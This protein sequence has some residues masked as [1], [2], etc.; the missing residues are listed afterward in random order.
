MQKGVPRLKVMLG[1]ALTGVVFLLGST[2]THGQTDDHEFSLQVSPSP[3]I[4]TVK[5]GQSTRLE[6]KVRNAGPAIEYL[7]IAPRSFTIDPTTQQPHI[8][9]AKLPDTASWIS[10]A[11]PTFSVR[12]GETFTEKVTLAVPKE[13]G[14][15]YAFS[16][17]INRTEAPQGTGRLL[18]GS[19][20]IFTLI[21]VDRPGAVRELQLA[22]LKPTQGM[23]EYLPA[24]FQIQFKNT[25]N[26]IVQPTG[27][28]FV[29]RGSQDKMPL[30]TL[31]VND[32]HGYILPGMVRTVSVKWDDGF[33]ASVD[34]VQA[35][36]STTSH[37]EWDWGKLGKLRIGRY[38]A[39]LVAIYDDGHR[40]VPV[41]G[42]VSFWVIPW[43]ILLGVLLV[44]VIIGFG[45]WSMVSKVVRLARRGRR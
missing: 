36:G 3:L 21:N 43:K 18:K 25:G 15:S 14:F 12:P 2:V 22:N 11:Q 6:L 39:K 1:V 30:A 28:L 17:V 45:L 33:P 40:D 23:Y 42:E 8:D 44:V 19:V 5:P 24:E 37:L 34:D 20:A 13:A 38:T 16:L 41:L 7:K 31:P 35:D 32:T 4:S 29:Q 27:N 10:F 26:T 9:D